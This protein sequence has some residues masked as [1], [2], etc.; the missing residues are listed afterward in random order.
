MREQA[1]ISNHRVTH[2]KCACGFIRKFVDAC[3]NIINITLSV[4][5]TLNIRL[6]SRTWFFFSKLTLVH[7][8]RTCRI[9]SLLL[10]HLNKNA[11]K[12]KVVHH[13]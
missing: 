11:F 4:K 3:N 5:E 6:P 7:I 13:D 8:M 12:V 9:K 10:A 2:V 1:G